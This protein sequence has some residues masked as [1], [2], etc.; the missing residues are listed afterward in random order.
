MQLPKGTKK[1]QRALSL[2]DNLPPQSPATLKA[3]GSAATN[4]KTLG[5]AK[6]MTAHAA[7]GQLPVPPSVSARHTASSRS[8]YN[9]QSLRVPLE[10]L[11]CPAAINKAL[12]AA[13]GGSLEQQ[14]PL[15]MTVSDYKKPSAPG[16]QHAAGCV[17]TSGHVCRP[18]WPAIVDL[19]EWSTRTT[20]TSSWLTSSSFAFTLPAQPTVTQT[21]MC[22]TASRTLEGRPSTRSTSSFAARMQRRELFSGSLAGKPSKAL[23]GIGH[24]ADVKLKAKNVYLVRDCVR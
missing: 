7:R 8:S 24:V 2:I 6:D 14:K 9:E 3:A 1:A 10:C 16:N 5:A 20:G 4:L 23:P 15:L 17:G 21:H 18:S 11:C 19:S 22:G 13:N 12:A